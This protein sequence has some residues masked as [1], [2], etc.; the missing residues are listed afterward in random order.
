MKILIQLIENYSNRIGF[1][2]I[3]KFNYE[4]KK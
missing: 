2:N 3:K 1:E 4:L